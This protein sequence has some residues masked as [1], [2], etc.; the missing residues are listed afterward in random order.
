MKRHG[1]LWP[2]V[3]DFAN[4]AA[5]ARQ[6]HCSAIVEY[7]AGLRLWMHPV[8][9]QLFEARH[10]AS[11]VGFRV[12]PDRIR[13]RAANLRRTRRRLR[14]WQRLYRDGK[15]TCA[16]VAQSLRSWGGAPCAWR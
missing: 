4:L 7:L 9:T 6:A 13:V 2:Q 14:G 16:E 15:A 1:N 10:G 8:K 5:A 12:L 11:F 3:I